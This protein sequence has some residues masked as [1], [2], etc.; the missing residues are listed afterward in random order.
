[1]GKFLLLFAFAIMFMYLGFA[2]DFY[3]ANHWTSTP[4]KIL[5]GCLV[6]IHVVYM[7]LHL[8]YEHQKKGKD[9]GK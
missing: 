6:I 7:L 3:L 4:T 1:M 5:A 2:A 8:S 9:N